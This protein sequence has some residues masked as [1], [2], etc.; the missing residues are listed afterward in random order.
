MFI[1]VFI[2]ST[3]RSET[4]K[5]LLQFCQKAFCLCFPLRVLQYLVLHLGLESFLNVIL[6]MMLENV[7]ILH[8]AVWFFQPHLLKILPFL[9]CMSLLNFHR[10][11]DQQLHGFI[12]SFSILY[13]YLYLCVCVPVPVCSVTQSCLTLQNSLDCSPPGSSVHVFPRQEYQSGLP[14]PSPGDLPDPG[15]EPRSSAWQ[16]DSLPLNH[17]QS[18]RLQLCNKV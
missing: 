7:I 16:V 18:P 2:F 6:W 11:I 1:F 15:I 10:L 14:F 3:Q 8:V 4:K 5:V 9:N 17:L 12:S 13:F